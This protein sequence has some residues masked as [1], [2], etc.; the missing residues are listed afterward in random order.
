MITDPVAHPHAKDL[1]RAWS[2]V[3]NEDWRHLGG[4][5]LQIDGYSTDP[6][7][8]DDPITAS[9]LL[10]ARRA[11]RPETRRADPWQRP[12][13]EDWALLAQWHGVRLVD[14]D[15]Y[16]TIARKDVP[17]RRFDQATVLG[18]FEGPL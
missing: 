17:T 13:P 11:G 7:G 9:A 1:R 15:V 2:E 10:A 14:G 4:A 5:H 3:R 16:W 6:Y 18:F 8:G 12:G